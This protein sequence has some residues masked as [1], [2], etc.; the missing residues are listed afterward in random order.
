MIPHLWRLS[1]VLPTLDLA[2]LSVTHSF[3]LRF[4]PGGKVS[5]GSGR[6]SLNGWH[7]VSCQ[8]S[9]LSFTAWLCSRPSTVRKL[10]RD[11]SLC[12]TPSWQWSGCRGSFVCL[13]HSII[14]A[15]S[16]RMCGGGMPD[17]LY[18]A[19]KGVDFMVPVINRHALLSSGS[20]MCAWHDLA[21]TGALYSAVE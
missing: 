11:F 21:H 12:L 19:G 4:A 10:L 16:R 14:A 9:S 8:C 2:L 18:N 15:V 1:L 3:L 6:A 17:S 7:S 20:T 13:C 5:S